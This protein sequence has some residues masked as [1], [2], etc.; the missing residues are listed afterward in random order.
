M[1]YYRSARSRVRH[2]GEA[3]LLAGVQ[4]LIGNNRRYGG[5]IV[6]VGLAILAIGVVWSSNFRN[7]KVME[8]GR[9]QAV[10]IPD[11][12]YSV[13][14]TGAEPLEGQKPYHGERVDFVIREL[15]SD[16]KVARAAVMGSEEGTIVATLY[17]E[18]RTYP[19]QANTI[20][21]PAIARGF[22]NDYRE[23][24]DASQSGARDS[25]RAHHDARPAN[26]PGTRYPI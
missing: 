16:D 6:H 3:P 18:M 7:M 21:V 2:R 13:E 15:V 10:E 5:Y 4:T 11:S 9:G 14:W 25:R 12:A 26:I 1:E 23:G 17:P 19:K 22:Y 20:S 24:Q 8:I